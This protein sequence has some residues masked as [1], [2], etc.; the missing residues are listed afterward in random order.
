MHGTQHSFNL[1]KIQR[2]LL[3]T[4]AKNTY[5]I[6]KNKTANDRFCKER[7]RN[8]VNKREEKHSLGLLFAYLKSSAK[9]QSSFT[10][11]IIV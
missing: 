3:M 10:V 6:K 9:L 1:F 8:R 5:E 4:S 7:R 11:S 2:T